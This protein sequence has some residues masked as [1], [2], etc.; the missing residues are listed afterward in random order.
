LFPPF[1]YKES[2]AGQTPKTTLGRIVVELDKGDD[3]GFF[4]SSFARKR[5][6]RL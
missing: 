6:D 3:R 1:F 2:D 4:A 5:S